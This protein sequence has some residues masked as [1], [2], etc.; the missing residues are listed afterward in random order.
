VTLKI[1]EKIM[2]KNKSIVLILL[3]LI[4]IL[5][6]SLTFSDGVY[7]G[8]DLNEVSIQRIYFDQN[9]GEIVI[10]ESH[11]VE[12][13]IPTDFKKTVKTA[14]FPNQVAER[15]MR[16]YLVSQMEKSKRR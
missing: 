9:S 7:V 4:L 13:R 3:S 16:E 2:K 5:Q 6:S 11:G 10:K 14:L 8:P 12:K 1:S 15:Y